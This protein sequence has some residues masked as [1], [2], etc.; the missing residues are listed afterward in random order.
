MFAADGSMSGSHASWRKPRLRTMWL[1]SIHG[2]GRSRPSP[3]CRGLLQPEISS[4]LRIASASPGGGFN[5]NARRGARSTKHLL[6]S[7]S[8]GPRCQGRRELLRE[9]PPREEIT[10]PIKQAEPPASGITGHIR[11]FAPLSQS[12]QRI[13]VTPGN[14]PTIALEPHI[15]AGIPAGVRSAPSFADE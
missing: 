12:F 15:R 9:V 5:E 2:T 4:W 7:I 11:F 13:G 3:R 6:R 1:H 8:L 14:R 10:T